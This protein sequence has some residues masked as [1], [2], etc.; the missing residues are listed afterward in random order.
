[1]CAAAAVGNLKRL[2][3]FAIANADLSQ[4]GL[5]GKTPLHCA[6]LHNK[7]AVVKFLLEQ[8]VETHKTD[9]TGQSPYDFAKTVGAT[10]VITLLSHLKPS[11]TP[12][13]IAKTAT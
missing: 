9:K 12:D 11:D 7:V 5:S 13:T 3:S 2:K 8:G 4:Q 6:A 10:E 1:M